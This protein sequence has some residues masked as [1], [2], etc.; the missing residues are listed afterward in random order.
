MLNRHLSNF[1]KK[2]QQG[3]ALLTILLLVVSITVIAGSMLASQKVMLRQYVLTQNQD[4]IREYALAGEAFAQQI[5]LKDSQINQNDS[6]QDIWAKPL[7]PY[8]VTNG[9][10]AVSLQDMASKFNLNN[11]YHDGAIDKQALAYFQR[12]LISQGIE[13]TIAQAVL[14]W[15]DP[16]SEVSSEGGAEA[17]FYQ[18]TGKKIPIANQPFISVNELAYI[19]GMNQEKFLKIQHLLTAVPF[20]LPMNVNTIQPELLVALVDEGLSINNLEEWANARKENIA[21]EKIADFWA[22]PPFT[23]IPTDKQTEVG[24]L[25]DVQSLAFQVSVTIQVNQRTN[26][27]T[28]LLAKKEGDI[29]AFNRQFLPYSLAH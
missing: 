11:L 27:F 16:D 10:V 2:N 1:S 22:L 6:L 13:P 17:E 12:L 14:D 25:L 4:Q 19:R 9:T 23:N 8:P 21:I 29:V 7:P 18:S 26:H 15:Q 24:N 28:S 5:L 20:F 3:V